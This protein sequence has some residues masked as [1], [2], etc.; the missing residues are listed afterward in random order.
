MLLDPHTYFEITIMP[1]LVDNDFGAVTDLSTADPESYGP[2]VSIPDED[3]RDA[4]VTD[5]D[6][7][8]EVKLPKKPS[9]FLLL[10]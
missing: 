1:S 10:L 8:A 2:R 9:R 6:V 4:V 7:L 3:P 5:L